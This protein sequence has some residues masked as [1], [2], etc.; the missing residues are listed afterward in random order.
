MKRTKK[1]I[2]PHPFLLFGIIRAIPG[3]G[4]ICP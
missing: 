4:R 3:I 2:K 1:T